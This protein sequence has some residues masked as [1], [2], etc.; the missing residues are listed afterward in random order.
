MKGGFPDVDGMFKKLPNLP[1]MPGKGKKGGS[2]KVVGGGLQE[3]QQELDKAKAAA[4][5]EPGNDELQQAVIDAQKALDNAAPEGEVKAAPD[6]GPAETAPADADT[7]IVAVT[8]VGDGFTAKIVG[9]GNSTGGKRRKRKT[10]AKKSK[11]SKKG[12]RKARKG[13][14]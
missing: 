10:A 7:T 11:K 12:T 5:L 13:R 4:A 8:K 14:K 3:L 9:D 1:G 6:A 2:K